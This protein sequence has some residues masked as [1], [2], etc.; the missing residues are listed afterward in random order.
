V[1]FGDDDRRSIAGLP[2]T[3]VRAFGEQ[4]GLESIFPEQL[5]DW[6][7]LH[8]GQDPALRDPEQFDAQAGHLGIFFQ[9]RLPEIRVEQ[10]LVHAAP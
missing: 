4:A 8:G 2:Q 3:A 5:D 9:R 6:S 10:V 1:C 7:G